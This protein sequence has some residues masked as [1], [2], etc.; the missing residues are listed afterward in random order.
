M[1]KH[2]HTFGK[3]LN[4]SFKAASLKLDPSLIAIACHLARIAAENDYKNVPS[5]DAIPY[6]GADTKGGPQ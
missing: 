5:S 3:T 4:K 6:T 2:D 1:S